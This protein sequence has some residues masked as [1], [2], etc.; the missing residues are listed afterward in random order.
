MRCR[1]QRK[2]VE[3]AFFD[4]MATQM[5]AAGATSLSARWR[6]AARNGPA[7]E[8]FEG[9][10]FRLHKTDAETGTLT[11]E[12]EGAFAGADIVTVISTG[13]NVPT[14]QNDLTP[15]AKAS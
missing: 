3:A 7:V 12:I 14:S 11:R 8:M 1:V 5:R 4:W 6:K 15:L 13:D 10:G 9:L 2:Q